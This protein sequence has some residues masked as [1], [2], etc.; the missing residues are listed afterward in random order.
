MLEPTQIE[1]LAG[2]RIIEIAAGGWHSSALSEFGDLY[3]WGWNKHGQLGMPLKFKKTIYVL[4]E[5]VDVLDT[6][7][8]EPAEITLIDCGTS[9]T[10]ICTKSGKL[11]G[12][13]STHLG[14]LAELSA[15]SG[16]VDQLQVITSPVAKV[17]K[18]ICNFAASF[19]FS[20]V[21]PKCQQSETK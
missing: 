16:F 9:H 15:P 10:V 11:F 21:P 18:I 20:S 17:E 19:I 4:P 1:A 7:S 5:I 12:A 2:I 6:N 13:G 8:D 14:Q 3:V